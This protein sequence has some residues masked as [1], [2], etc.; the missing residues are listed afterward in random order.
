MTGWTVKRVEQ[1]LYPLADTWS[2]PREYVVYSCAALSD[3][4]AASDALY[5]AERRAAAAMPESSGL[6]ANY[7]ND[8]PIMFALDYRP[9]NG[10]NGPARRLTRKVSFHITEAGK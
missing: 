10:P 8:R 3:A 6:G 5:G 2:E 1:D 7:G 9:A 4:I